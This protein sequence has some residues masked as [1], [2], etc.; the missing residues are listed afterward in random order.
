MIKTYRKK[1]VDVQA[2]QWTGNNLREV[3]DFTGL[4]ESADSWSWDQYERVVSTSGLKVF[5]AEG[6]LNASI[7]DFIVRGYS[8]KQGY[9]FWPVKPDYFE[10]S[11]FELTGNSTIQP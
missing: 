3:I 9:H 8:E 4:H 10:Q 2:I 7:G 1:P 11:Y 6:P 5:T